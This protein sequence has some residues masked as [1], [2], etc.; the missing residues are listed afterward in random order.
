[1]GRRLGEGS[2]LCL[3]LL[4][5]PSLRPG[6]GRRVAAEPGPLRHAH[7][8]GRHAV[9][10]LHL[11]LVR[12]QRG[13]VG[14]PR[15]PVPC[16]AAPAPPPSPRSPQVRGGGRAAALQPPEP[17]RQ[18]AAAH[19]YHVA[20][21][22][23]GGG[24][25]VVRPQR[26]AQPRS[27]RVP[28]GGP[29]LC[30]LLVRVLLLPALPAHAA[31]LLGHVPGPSALGG[32]PP[33]Q[34]ARPSAPPPQR[35]RPAAPRR[36]PG[37]RCRRVPGRHP[38]PRLHPGPRRHPAPRRH[39]G[40]RC[41]RAPRRHPSLGCRRALGRHAGRTP[42]AGPQEETGQDH[43]PGAQSYESPACG[44]R[45]VPAGGR[46]RRGRLQRPGCEA[47]PGAGGVAGSRSR[48]P[49]PC[50]QGPFCCAGRPSLSCTSPERCVPRAPCP[51]G[52]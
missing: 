49:Q 52:W 13:Q 34:A 19:R 43:G 12:H 24:A 48:Q 26:R 50:P 4:R 23:S 27:L 8:H 14:R 11:Q 18:A 47:A 42:A 40:P 25:R 28:P 45:W 36:Q 5:S 3:L 33:R 38:G 44:G 31:A 37:P 15:R 30:G 9:H 32:S 29:R 7:G 10:G 35:P 1:M 51:R 6:P 46:G 21:V 17:R 20:A 22:G 41:R 2:V 16:R 39:P